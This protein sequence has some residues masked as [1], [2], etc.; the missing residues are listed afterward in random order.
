MGYKRTYR[1]SG[2]APLINITS[3]DLATNTGY[4]DLLAV[5]D[6]VSYSL[7]TQPVAGGY[8]LETSASFASSSL[9]NLISKTYTMNFPVQQIVKGNAYLTTTIDFTNGTGS[10]R[11]DGVL[12]INGVE[13]SRQ[14]GVEIT[15]PSPAP[16]TFNTCSRATLIMPI[17]TQQIVHPG[18]VVSLNVQ[19][20]AKATAGG[21]RTIRLYQDPENRD[22]ASGGSLITGS[23]NFCSTTFRN[24]TDLKLRLPLKLI[25]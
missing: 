16:S 10:Y 11:I 8:V 1:S 18:D 15:I 23:S 22:F 20:L 13:A 24:S 21:S 7:V 6:S 5:S 14:S 19:V 9:I 2:E 12:T 3:T 4:I 17:T 25:Q